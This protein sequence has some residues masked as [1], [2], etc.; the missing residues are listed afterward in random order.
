MVKP[1][2][3][4][5]E[6][7]NRPLSRSLRLYQRIA[8]SFVV[9]AF[10]LLIGVVYL[11][12]SR[13]TIKVISEPK[14]ISVNAFADVVANPQDAN[15]IRGIVN[16]I[17]LDRSKLF[18]LPA[19]G[20]RA[21]E[22]KAGGYV[23]LVNGTNNDQPLVATTRLLSETGVL[24]RLRD[25][26]TVP[27][28]GQVEAYA[29]ADQPG[30]AGEIPAGTFTIPG[31][32]PTLQ[33][34]IVGMSTAPMVGGVQYVRTLTESDIADASSALQAELL[35]EAKAQLQA[36]VDRAGLE[37]EAF[38]IEILSQGTDTQIGAEAGAFTLTMR[39]RVAVVYFDKAAVGS[40]ATIRLQEQLPDGF[41][42]IDE[43][44]DALQMEVLEYSA[45]DKTARVQAYL[46]GVALLSE[47][48]AIVAK[49]RFLGRSAKEVE[50]LLRASEAVSDVHVSFT[51]FWLQRVP[52]LA[53]HVRITI[54][55]AK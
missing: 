1:G 46:D 55:A 23:T 9:V 51:P 33:K 28:N 37:G 52:S 36:D 3:T 26:V 24:F 13:A 21:V 2:R 25:F 5:A 50:T 12:I 15:D 22:Q 10:L 38:D 19:E 7:G 35:A 48:A 4:R 41:K 34:S 43:Q 54:E 30:K 40:V 18:I 20:A 29:L 39:A 45:T 42:L 6:A 8:V 16:E 44:L 17:T 49:D 53:D 27:A 31:L 47:D 14:T 11:S 32:N